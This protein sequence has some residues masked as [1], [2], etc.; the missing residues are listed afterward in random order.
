MKTMQKDKNTYYNEPKDVDEFQLWI[1]S[2]MLIFV[3]YL[4][5]I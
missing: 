4:H 3:Q 5:K 1:H 2:F